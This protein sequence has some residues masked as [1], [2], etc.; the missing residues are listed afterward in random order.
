MH[1]TRI[2]LEDIKSHAHFEEN[3]QRG[4]TAITG[5]NGAGKTTLIEAIAWTL[6]DLLDYKKD[7]FVRRGAKKG[8]ARVTFESGLDGREYTVYRDTGTGYFVYDIQLKTRIAEKKE[9]VARFLWQHLGVE[10]GTDLEALFRR[11]IGV[12]QGTFTAIFLETPTERKKAFDKLLKVEEYR[13]GAERLLQ[14]SRYV[15]QKITDTKIR[16]G[17]AEGEL[18]RYEI[19]AENLKNLTAETATLAAALETLEKE[20]AAKTEAV[21]AFNETEKQVDALKTVF[22][23]AQTEKTR[24]EFLRSQRENELRQAR[25]ASESVERVAADHEKHLAA[26]GRLKELE[27]ERGER[28]KLAAEQRRVET[29]ALQVTAD[30]KRFEENLEKTRQAAREIEKLQPLVG[31]QEAL[32]KRRDDLIEQLAAVR[33]KEAEIR[34][35]DEKMNDLRAKYTKNKEQLREAET[36]ASAA[37]DCERLQQRDSELTREITRFRAK[38]EHDEQFQAEVKNG[39]CPILSQKCLNLKPGETLDSFLKDQFTE[40]R[41]QIG[42]LET[43]QKTIAG[44]L[45]L[46]REA[47]KYSAML[48]N[49][50]QREAEIA[51]EGKGYRDEKEALIKDLGDKDQ[52]Q[53]DLARAEA[54]LKTLGNPRAKIQILDAETKRELVI[55][56]KLSEIEKNLERLESERCTLAERLESYRD[57]DANW[58]ES[59]A[60]R[61]RTAAAHREYLA[62]ENAAR[63]L[64]ERETEFAQADAGLTAAAGALE[65][66]ER[67]FRAAAGAY[68]RERHQAEKYALSELEKRQAETRAHLANAERGRA[69]AEAELARLAEI[70]RAMQ[71]EFQ[72][73]ERLEQVAEATD[74]IR[75]TLK[76]SAPLVAK[77]Y[78]Y[79]VSLEANQM[80]REITGNAERTLRWTEDYGIVLEEDGFDRPFVNLSGGEQMAAALAVRLALL[81]QLS[82]IRLAFFDE[83]TT[84]MDAARRE[85]LAEQISHITERKTFDQLFVISHDD[86]FEG[87]VDN[88]VAVGKREEG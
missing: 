19:E 45:R 11:A 13:Q 54:D 72:E 48:D 21:A 63:Q 43:E 7:D 51:D 73:K 37:K 88:V 18:A 49:L 12:P 26:L 36:K 62:N 84:N 65:T 35:L 78:I 69:Q 16:I 34:R 27:R 5:E 25:A 3:F 41:A 30:R 8:V 22:D 76:K 24:A 81:K 64:P 53:K 75:E 44:D 66:A 1:I 67:E 47:D 86:T 42:A 56:E 57:L 71:A 14:T 39:L 79:Y 83:P 85:R 58:A 59:S 87:Y 2:E 77:N 28:E 38:L 50:R 33:A 9:E 20:V 52:L 74:F 60:E 40:A 23:R 32:E 82:D 10:A 4:T 55:R 29:A 68:D 61:D 46:A 6:F 17:R 70:R 80:F 31:E 15:E